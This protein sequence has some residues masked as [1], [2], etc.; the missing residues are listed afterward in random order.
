MKILAVIQRYH[1]VIGGSENLAKNFLDYMSK[2]HSVTVY[3]TNADDIQ[4]FWYKN[5]TR[6]SDDNDLEYDVVRN[7]FLV[8]T[9]IKY[10]EI[11]KEFPFITNYPGPFSP[12]MWNELVCKKIDFDLIYVTSF[13]HDHVFPAYVASKKWNIPIII[14]P[15]IHQEFPELY[16]TSTKLT[17]L[18]NSDA[19]FVISE[20]EKNTLIHRGVKENK[21]SII[22]PYTNLVFQEKTENGFRKKFSIGDNK[23]VLFIG[24][25]S[26]VKGT[27]HVIEAL[28][29]IWKEKSDTVLVLIGPATEEYKEFYSKLPNNIQ[30]KIID[31]GIIDEEVKRDVI[32]EC[33][34]LVL[35][36]K[37][38]SFGLV[39]LEAWMYEKP[40]IGCNI[41]PISNLIDDKKN[42]LL[43]EFGNVNQLK[44]SILYLLNNSTISQEYG[45]DGK[46]KALKLNSLENL[47]S[48]EEKCLSVKDSFRNKKL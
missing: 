38:E 36:S 40:V 5:S 37:S 46:N 35:P 43:V 1:P 30:E 19:V 48:F 42:G 29:K 2:N 3:T 44:D 25:R 6:I 26:F 27:I 16:L 13:P 4:S 18:N 41:P 24:S 8:P 28:K 7:D 14:T 15:L 12:K 20:S 32:S 11:V 17:M 21:I 31:L 34:L 39:Y 23:I 10:D 33:D 9:E 22:Q 47:K 45:R